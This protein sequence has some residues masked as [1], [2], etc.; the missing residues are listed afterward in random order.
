MC[1]GINEWAEIT[2]LSDEGK[3]RKLGMAVAT[4]IVTFLR[5]GL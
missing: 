2:C 5:G 4:K 1:A 3:S